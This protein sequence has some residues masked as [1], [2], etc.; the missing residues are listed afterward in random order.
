MQIGESLLEGPCEEDC[1][2]VSDAGGGGEST[3]VSHVPNVA[4]T[5]AHTKKIIFLKHKH[6]QNNKI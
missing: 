6:V 5:Y 3:G 4:F 1:P 2:G